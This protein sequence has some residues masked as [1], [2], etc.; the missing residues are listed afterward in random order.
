MAVSL[1]G[2][3]ITFVYFFRGVSI[4]YQEIKE[5]GRFSSHD[6]ALINKGK[7]LI[8][9][10]ENYSRVRIILF[11]NDGLKP[12]LSWMQS[13]QDAP[14]DISL[15]RSRTFGGNHSIKI[16]MKYFGATDSDCARLLSEDCEIKYT[17]VTIS[18]INEN[19]IRKIHI[20]MD[21]TV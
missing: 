2:I 1:I 8:L 13:T 4:S 18:S 12:E 14:H 16:V 21:R 20:R 11:G 15:F 19:D 10:K 9:Y 17:N 3:I 5:V 7:T 6:V